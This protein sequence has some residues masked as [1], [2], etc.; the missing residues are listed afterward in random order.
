MAYGLSIT[1]ANESFVFDTSI[2][3]ATTMPV[4]KDLLVSQAD[5]RT[6]TM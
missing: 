6:Q 4:L 3:G 1:G 5:S 2:A